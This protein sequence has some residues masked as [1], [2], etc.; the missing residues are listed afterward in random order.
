MLLSG[1]FKRRSQHQTG[2]SK[3]FSLFQMASNSSV[4]KVHTSEK[5]NETE[6]IKGGV[7]KVNLQSA[8]VGRQRR[9]QLEAD[10]TVNVPAQ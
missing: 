3:P 7:K 5:E 10:L 8:H 1:R 9:A 2:R 4:R 6:K